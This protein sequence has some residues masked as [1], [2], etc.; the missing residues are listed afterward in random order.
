MLNLTLLPA[1]QTYE[2]STKHAESLRG[3][4]GIAGLQTMS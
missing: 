1:N 4:H 2:P 3:W